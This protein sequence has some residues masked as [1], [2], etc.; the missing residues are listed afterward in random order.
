MLPKPLPNFIHAGVPK[1]ASATINSM[2]RKHPDVFLPRQK[3][4]GFF[5]TDECFSL[6]VD[7]Y[8]TTYF[9]SVVDQRI[10]GDMS[11]GYSTG[12]GF[13][14]PIRIAETLGTDLKILLTFRDP[15]ARAYSQYGMASNKGQFERLGFAEAIDRAIAVGPSITSA[16]R[17][18]ARTGTY[19]SSGKDMDVFRWCMYVEPGHYADIL[20]TWTSIFGVDN[21]LV[22]LTEDIAVDLQKE[23]SRLFSFL[24]IESIYV[25]PE[26]RHNTATDLRYPWLRRVLNQFY[27]IGSL[28]SALNSPHMSPLRKILRKRFLSGNYVQNNSVAAPSL[29]AVKSLRSHYEPQ[30][31]RLEGTLGRDLS[32]WRTKYAKEVVAK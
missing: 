20:E 1:S 6:G 28:R 8:S 30:I 31:S 18:R 19:Y 12:F 24:D 15:I 13:D 5:N 3:E 25:E 21:V 22:I 4:P 17:L 26:L 2:F 14:A 29:E 16:D 7:W 23:A 27:A 10:V 11:I 9:S 32:I